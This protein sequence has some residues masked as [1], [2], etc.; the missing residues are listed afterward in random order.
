MA[1][2][3][4]CSRIISD[5]N[6]F[7]KQSCCYL[8]IFFSGMFY[9]SPRP[10][11]KLIKPRF[12]DRWHLMNEYFWERR[13]MW[14]QIYDCTEKLLCEWRLTLFCSLTSA[15]FCRDTSA[16]FLRNA[17]FCLL[18]RKIKMMREEWISSHVSSSQ[19]DTRLTNGHIL[20]K[21][22]RMDHFEPREL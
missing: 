21:V 14:W 6:Q 13:G 18:R 5:Y 15:V 4:W 7:W 3:I 11:I 17:P 2:L 19:E 9:F 10:T 12:F 8:H 1:M 22:K 20:L 16:G